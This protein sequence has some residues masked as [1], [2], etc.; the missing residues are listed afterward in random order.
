MPFIFW[1]SLAFLL[2]SAICV[3]FDVFGFRR[4]LT[5]DFFLIFNFIL[6]NTGLRGRKMKLGIAKTA[7]YIFAV[8]LLLLLI[9]I[10]LSIGIPYSL[11]EE[12]NKYTGP[13]GDLFNGILTPVLTFLTFC[14]F[15][16]TIL[17]QNIQ[18][19]STLQEL[20]LTRKEMA[21]S[22]NALEAQVRN[23]TAQKFDNNF[24]SLLNYH[25]K[26]SDD[27]VKMLDDRTR[28]VV[29]NEIVEFNRVKESE[30]FKFVNNEALTSY[31]LIN[32]Q[33]L[34]FVDK[35]EGELLSSDEAKYYV[36]IL[37]SVIPSDLLFLIFLNCAGDNYEKYK[38]I[39]VKYNFFEHLGFSGVKNKLILNFIKSYDASVYGDGVKLKN[40]FESKLRYRLNFHS[41][42]SYMKLDKL[43]SYLGS[44]LASCKNRDDRELNRSLQNRINAVKDHVSGI[45]GCID[46]D[47]VINENEY[48][49]N[50]ID[51]NFKYFE[52]IYFTKSDEV[53]DIYRDVD[54]FNKQMSISQEE[55]ILRIL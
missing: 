20:D 16:I 50:F 3:H 37:R 2:G 52:D 17:I 18:M 13:L 30:N 48:R 28:S 46:F 21:A 22:T 45:N 39:L 25:S 9:S 24:F 11:G 33:I 7:A 32:Y 1:A 23:S 35:N 40:F 12:E 47:R 43:Y 41:S 4:R 36:N 26:V 54:I 8:V 31:F 38:N 19:K 14:G 42:E 10:F 51:S 29:N 44:Q 55:Y 15:L 49:M 5:R 34:K 53:R 6:P 27:L